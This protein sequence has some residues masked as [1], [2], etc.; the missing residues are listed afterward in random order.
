MFCCEDIPAAL[1]TDSGTH[2][3]AKS[4]EERI[5]RF[6]CRHSLSAPRHA[7]SNGLAEIFYLR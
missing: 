4:L 1:I 7:Q 2:F 5:K 3:T 6:G